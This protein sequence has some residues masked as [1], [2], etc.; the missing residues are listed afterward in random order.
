MNIHNEFFGLLQEQNILRTTKTRPL[1][2]AIQNRH[3]ISFMYIGPRKPENRSVKA[4]KRIKVEAVALGLS[5]KGN[6]IIRG[7]VQPPSASKTGF[8]EH[9]WRTFM[10]S[11]M[12]SIQV[13]DEETFDTKRPG[14]QEGA[15]S[16]SGPMQTTYIT[17]DWNKKPE[18]PKVKKQTKKQPEPAIQ[19]Q[20]QPEVQPTV[21]VPIEKPEVP[22][23]IDQNKPEQP[24]PQI[25]KPIDKIQPEPSTDLP[26]IKPEDK[27]SQDPEE[28]LNKTLKEEMKR[29][30]SLIS[31]K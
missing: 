5:R 15:E 14:Y 13:F 8:N 22:T 30:K 12:S 3:P 16:K 6:L 31:Y 11:R 2:D 19:N 10:V 9:G 17:S 21:D 23:N 20:P 26:P 28:D 29:M 7:Y 18:E 24:K 25:N 27:P 4:G 1:V